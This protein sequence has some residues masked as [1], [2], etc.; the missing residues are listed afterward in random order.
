MW[1]AYDIDVTEK[2]IRLEMNQSNSESAPVLGEDGVLR[3]LAQPEVYFRGLCHGFP[4]SE[5]VTDT[6]R[7]IPPLR[8]PAPPGAG[9]YQLQL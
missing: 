2:N 1:K 9:G 8:I 6:N 3:W 7:H 4:L 5:Q